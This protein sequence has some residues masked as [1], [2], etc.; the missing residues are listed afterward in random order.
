MSQIWMV[1]RS[2]IPS[3][4][5]LL[6]LGMT[7]QVT[8]GFCTSRVPETYSG[9]E[10]MPSPWQPWSWAEGPECGGVLLLLG[11]WRAASQLGLILLA[12]ARTAVL[13]PSAARGSGAPCVF[14]S[15][16]GSTGSCWR[17]VRGRPNK[18]ITGSRGRL[19]A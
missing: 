16:V 18:I 12:T 2:R 9:S 1:P 11:S 19:L 13:L 5:P 15:L 8:M 10:S 6:S 17:V 3:P 14:V 4:N 7:E